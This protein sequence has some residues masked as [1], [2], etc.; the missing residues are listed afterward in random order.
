MLSI[1]AIPANE[2]I[3]FLNINNIQQSSD[4]KQNYL[5]AWDL[6]KSNNFVSASPSI[7]D[8]IIA[9]NLATSNI[10]LSPITL[11]DVL[12]TSDANLKDLSNQLGLQS[13][14][15]ER[16][17]RILRYSNA[18]L[19]DIYFLENLPNDVIMSNYFITL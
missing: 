3:S 4:I 8:W 19:D 2:I 12:S 16:L 10:K 15:K 18:L 14:D 17:I 9:M 13:V 7:N 5:L 11:L 6:L 1:T